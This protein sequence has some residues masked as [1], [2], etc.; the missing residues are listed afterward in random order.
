[1]LAQRH[2]MEIGAGIAAGDS[3]GRTRPLS[4]EITSLIFANTRLS[5]T[6]ALHRDRT[7][8]NTGIARPVTSCSESVAVPL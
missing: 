8:S 3:F 7:S 6:S 1:M 2:V 4:G 5:G